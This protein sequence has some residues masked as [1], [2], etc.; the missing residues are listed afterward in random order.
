M[1]PNR[2][3][4]RSPRC[5]RAVMDIAVKDVPASGND[6]PVKLGNWSARGEAAARREHPPVV[7]ELA[8]SAAIARPF[9]EIAQQHRRAIPRTIGDMMQHR[10][11]LLAAAQA[12][13]IEMHGN[14]AN[15]FAIGKEIGPDRAARFE[16]RE[17]H[18]SRFRDDHVAPHKDGVA[19]PADAIWLSADQHWLV[20]RVLLDRGERQS[21]HPPAKAPVRFLERDDIGV[22]LTQHGQDPI[23]IAAAVEADRFV[24]IVAGEGELHFSLGRQRYSGRLAGW[25]ARR[26]C[27]RAR[28]IWPPIHPDPA[29]HDI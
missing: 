23:G 1:R 13:E 10:A 18:N 12:R 24:D 21:A 11:D 29:R 16:R 22:D 2:Q 27:G 3:M 7:I 5:Q 28:H 26:C 17:R 20:M 14:H 8:Q 15:A 19:V 25:A 6:N 9:V 4:I